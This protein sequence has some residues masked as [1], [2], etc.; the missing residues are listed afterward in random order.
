MSGSFDG[1]AVRK[2]VQSVPA[3]PARTEA[4]L[5]AIREADLS[6][7]TYWRQNLRADM[8]LWTG[9]YDDCPKILPVCA[10]FFALFEEEPHAM[11]AELAAFNQYLVAHKAAELCVL[12]PQLE[13]PVCIGLLD[14]LERVVKRVGDGMRRRDMALCEFYLYVDAEKSQ[15]Y[16]ARFL[17]PCRDEFSSC[18]AC[19]QDFK[20]WYYL[21]TGDLE[22]AKYLAKPIFLGQ[23]VCDSVPSHTYAS[24]IQYYLDQGD[25]D[26]MKPLLSPLVYKGLHDRSDLLYLAAAIRGLAFTDPKKG[27]KLLRQGIGWSEGLWDR[28][29]MYEFYKGIWCLCTAPAL[30][31]TRVPFPA[32]MSA[33]EGPCTAP[34]LGAWA[35]KQAEK[36]AKAFDRRNGTRW[37]QENLE[38]AVSST[39]K[40]WRDGNGK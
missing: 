27:V 3:G 11:G 34:I 25:V 9:F 1:E 14:Q 39:E 40:I 16:F 33:P 35:R 18:R 31:G 20:V 2:R 8:V 21:H 37:Y 7:D 19:E 10:E 38:R 23:Y 30:E 12:L 36:I 28:Q 15:Q 17:M 24:F 26:S 5:A 32:D 29:S 4:Y 22:K 13:L 6:G